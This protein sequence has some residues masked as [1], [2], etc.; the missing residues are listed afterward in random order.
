MQSNLLQGAA[1]PASDA[2]LMQAI[3]Q[4]N[5]PA[6]DRNAM[7]IGVEDAQGRVY[8][9]VRTTGLCETVRFFE[10]VRKLGYDIHRGRAANEI[11]FQ[12]ILRWQGSN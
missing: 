12:K 9:V 10:S 1:A 7:T 4:L 2:S 5:A 8:R 11:S 6:D 3:A